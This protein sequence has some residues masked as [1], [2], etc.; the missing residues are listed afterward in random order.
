[1]TRVV[2]LRAEAEVELS[3]AASW[4]ERQRSGLGQAFLKAI[5][6]ALDRISD[7]PL[8]F[9]MVHRNVRRALPTRFP[10]GVF[11]RVRREHVI[12]LAVLHASRSPAR[13]K[14]Y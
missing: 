12:V 3:E 7:N 10:F 5:E 6:Q 2:S 9:P 13:W 11:F 8:Q 4:Y 1:M 14:S